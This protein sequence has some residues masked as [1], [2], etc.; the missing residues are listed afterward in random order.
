MDPIFSRP[1]L[2]RSSLLCMGVALGLMTSVH[3]HDSVVS[4]VVVSI[5]ALASV[6]LVSLFGFPS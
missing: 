4:M 3:I 5:L 1:A 2:H 6:V